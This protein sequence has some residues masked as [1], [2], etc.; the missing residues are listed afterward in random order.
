M[1]VDYVATRSTALLLLSTT[2]SGVANVEHRHECNKTIMNHV[3]ITQTCI[4]LNKP[5][6][7]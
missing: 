6:T 1:N 7:G 5:F 3:E 2:W 4:N